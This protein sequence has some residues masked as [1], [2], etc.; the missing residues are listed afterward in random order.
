M[1]VYFNV[2]DQDNAISLHTKHL[3]MPSTSQ[4]FRTQRFIGLSNTNPNRSRPALPGRKRGARV[5]P[6]LILQWLRICETEHTVQCT[7]MWSDRLLSSRMIDVKARKIVTCPSQ[8]R[9]VALSYMWGGVSP[10]PGA[11]EAGTLP[12]TIEDAITVTKA[13]GVDYLWVDALCIDQFASDQQRQQ[14]AMMDL[15]YSCAYITIVALHGDN[16]DSGLCG[17]RDDE[18]PR[19]SQACEVIDGTELVSI[20]ALAEL[21]LMTSQ[22]NTRAWTL[23]EFLLSPRRLVFGKNQ[24]HLLCNTAQYTETIDETVDPAKVLA[25][26]E[27][28]QTGFYFPSSHADAAPAS[29]L[30]V[31]DFHYR[32]LVDAYTNRKMTNSSDSL[33]AVLGALEYLR[34]AVLPGGFVFGLPLAELPQS[35][36]W[37]HHRS[38]QARRRLAF[39]SWS[40]VGWEG[41]ALYNET[42][43]LVHGEGEVRRYDAKTDLVVEYLGVADG[44]HHHTLR[45]RG[46][47]LRLEIRNQ[48]FNDGYVVGSDGGILVG[49]L[50]E[51]NAL[52]KN[53]LPEGVF[54][55]LVVE[56]L[57]YR[58]APEG[59]VRHALYLLMLDP[60]HEKGVWERRSMVRLFVEPG[61]ETSPEYGSLLGQRIDVKLE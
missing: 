59:R 16:A 7:R 48:P 38:V 17:V 60:G 18:S 61:F 5:D 54:D 31:A 6:A 14:L 26:P 41:P 28:T 53:T 9:Y 3:G 23:Q 57:T 12:R 34:K 44:G 33:N 51:G 39:P 50:H 15:L 29:R 40:F 32:Q 55:F 21:E 22:Y 46:N 42:L 19:P 52:H 8:C 2:E 11:L 25:P 49:M 37:I 13:I 45:L 4:L 10:Q 35:L 30:A 27:G 58:A 43:D 1:A 56:R 24:A 20:F 36:R 47:T